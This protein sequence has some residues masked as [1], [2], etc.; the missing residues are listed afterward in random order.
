MVVPGSFPIHDLPDI[1]IELPDG[2]GAYA[3]VAGYVLDQLGHI[4]VVGEVVDGEDWSVEVLDVVE[5]AITKVR[6]SP[7]SA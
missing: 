2:E 7:M 1:D 5:R 4:P 6:L 3:T